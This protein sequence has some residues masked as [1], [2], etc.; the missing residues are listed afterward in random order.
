MG[1]AARAREAPHLTMAALKACG[2]MVEGRLCG[3]LSSDPRCDAHAQELAYTQLQAK[4]EV[5]PYDHRDRIRRAEAVAAHKRMHGHWCPGYAPRGRPAHHVT[6]G[7]PLTADHE[8]SYAVSGSEAGML[9][10]RCRAC[11]ASKGAD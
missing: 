10:V 1:L 9:T 11:N 2:A 7:N 5:R 3:K 6:E 8:E 4:R